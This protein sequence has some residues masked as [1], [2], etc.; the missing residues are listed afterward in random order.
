MTAETDTR[1]AV[2]TAEKPAARDRSKPGALARFWRRITFGGFSSL[3][4][5][6]IF[7][8]LF[9][10]VVLV[11]AILFLNQ[12]RGSLIDAEVR[13][14]TAQ[15]ELIANSI[16]AQATNVPG[17]TFL[18]TPEEALDLEA[19]ADYVAGL[20]FPIDPAR[21]GTLITYLSASAGPRV[22]VYD[23]TGYRYVDSDATEITRTALP[24]PGEG[25]PSLLERIWSGIN[26]WFRRNDLPIYVEHGQSDGLLYDEVATAIAGE[27]T[28]L[29]RVTEAGELIVTVAVP[30]RGYQ[31]IQG[32]V[33]LTTREGDIDDIIRDERNAI[34]RVFAVAAAV[35]VLLSLL[36]AGTI[37]APLRRLAHAA[38]HVRKGVR[39]RPQI[40]DFSKRGDEIGDLSLA[41]RE[42]TSS[43][44]NRID[45]IERFAA[46][47]SH[48]L[49]NPL[50]SL[51]SAV[52]TLPLA[53]TKESQDRLA[54]VI[55]HDIKRLDRLISDISDAS[56]LDA[57]LSRRD[58]EPFDVAKLLQTLVT[59]SN[60]AS[61]RKGQLVLS[62]A[63]AD[64]DSYIVLG[65]DIRLTQVLSNLIDNARS[66]SPPDEEIRISA[67]RDGDEVEILVEDAGP[68]VKA[69]NIDRIFERFY[70][71]RPG[72]DAFGQNS[73][74]GLS[75]SKQIV[76]AHS[77][78]IWVENIP[79]PVDADKV[80][81][82][83]FGVRIPVAGR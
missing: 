9:A 3:T 36:L 38:D 49:K 22:R 82:A 27:R 1:I 37:A 5:R 18:R 7:L 68:G 11:V 13:S 51:R 77:G 53:K 45:A 20:D 39:S 42:M 56:R 80:V 10:L 83:R 8:N 57:E 2:D 73:G 24:P 54:A 59:L 52:E 71:D 58:A 55:Q 40:P 15:G 6:I 35:S 48:E 64:D 44:F 69:E 31:T 81:G 66:F 23:S 75:I 67:R 26:G 79:D 4:R 16:A 21:A 62:I 41:L 50:T 17:T 30:I 28:T 25:E 32:A 65:H 60:E 33:L 63:D 43:L 72:E 47:V 76:D 12:A 74:L 46:D 78:R 61:D 29:T 70:T 19:A 14:L 34:L